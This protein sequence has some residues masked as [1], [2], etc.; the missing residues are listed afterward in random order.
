M[1]AVKAKRLDIPA[2]AHAEFALEEGLITAPAAT[3]TG[4]RGREVVLSAP[5]AAGLVR[6]MRG[7]VQAA[8][9]PVQLRP[10][11]DDP[12]AACWLRQSLVSAARFA[13]ASRGL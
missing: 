11:L 13:Q 4:Q 7:L 1:I 6:I 3:G 8:W 12:T 2:M 10:G 9:P 5:G